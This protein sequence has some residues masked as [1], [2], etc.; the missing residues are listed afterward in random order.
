MAFEV[1]HQ[2]SVVPTLLAVLV[3]SQR[4][5]H[6][7]N[8][9]ESRFSSVFHYL[10]LFDST[11]FRPFDGYFGGFHSRLS[12]LND[13]RNFPSGNNAPN[14]TGDPARLTSIIAT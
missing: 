14:T 13:S 5:W 8:I 11:E 10:Y 12:M 9:Y 1:D 7:A 2:L 4:S 6:P 3:A